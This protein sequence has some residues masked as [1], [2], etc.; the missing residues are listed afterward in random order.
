MAKRRAEAAPCL[1]LALILATGCKVPESSVNEVQWVEQ[2]SGSRASLRGVCAV[3]RDVV[4]ASGSD[5]TCLRTTDGGATWRALT[6]HGAEAAD[7]RDVHAI[8]ERIAWLL[9]TEKPAR[10]Y[11]TEDGGSTWAVQHEDT[12]PGAFFDSFAFWSAT[13]G[14]VFGDP[15]DSVFTVLVT[16]D[17]GRTWTQTPHDGLPLPADGEAGF[18]ASGTCVAVQSGN[19]AWI[20]TGGTA[21]RVLRTADGGQSWQPL[22]T[23][24]RFGLP[25]TGIF[26]VAFRDADHGVLVGGDYKAEDSPRRNA[27]WTNDGGTVWLLPE[28][29]PPSGYR[30]CVAHWPG[31]DTT[32]IAVGPTGVDESYDDGRTW[33][34]ISPHGYHSLAFTPRGEAGWAVGSEGRIARL[35]K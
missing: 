5:G 30:S 31:P 8:D 33:R 11:H 29:E 13:S 28:G 3:S 4:W 27:V 1:V 21:T 10:I 9:A 22:D 35:A 23:P 20:G 7:F 14:I 25:S 34:P 15:V 17:G 2:H 16:H 12:R 24:M 19:L 6:V 26:S 18:A 32:W